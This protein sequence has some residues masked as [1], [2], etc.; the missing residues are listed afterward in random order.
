MSD[1]LKAFLR[2][3]SRMRANWS[4]RVSLVALC[5]KRT[6]KGQV[7]GADPAR[8]LNGYRKHVDNLTN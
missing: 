6:T 4:D 5:V 2:T 3:W 8:I 7:L 1:R